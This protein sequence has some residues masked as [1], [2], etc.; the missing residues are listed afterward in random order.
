MLRERRQPRNVSLLMLGMALTVAGLAALA[1]TVRATAR[2]AGLSAGCP[3]GAADIEA[4]GRAYFDAFNR[5]DAAALGELLS[6]DYDHH[7]AVV[8]RQDRALHVNRLLAV[9]SAFPDAVYTID[10]L[11]VDGDIVVTRW[12]FRG[13]QVGE[14]AGIPPSG[15]S[16]SIGGFHVHRVICG[17]IVETW[18]AG[19]ALGLFRQLGA[20]PGPATT[21][22][23][24]EAPAP[25]TSR[26]MP[27]PTTTAAQNATVARRWYDEALNQDRLD[28]LDRLLAPDVVHHAAVFVDLVGPEAVKG[29]LAALLAGFPGIQYTVDAVYAEGDRVLVRWTGRG[30]QNGEF[31]GV[32]PSGRA[33]EWSGM[34]AFRFSCGEIV[35]G[36]SE[37]NG[38]E[39]F[40]QIGALP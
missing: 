25:A 2:A 16:A 35:E 40:R 14:Y 34:N 18:N 9:R 1:P 5:G 10:W 23:D 33:V 39:I 13:T 30:T 29:S 37:A 12:I 3:S 11:F 19:D 6:A 8:A 4:V 31:L 38:L 21:P 24:Q 32:P 28:I 26:R 7:G 20:I 36:W 22:A 15:R 17:Q 27:C